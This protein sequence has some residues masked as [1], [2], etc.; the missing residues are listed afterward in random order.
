M[1]I[2]VPLAILLLSYGFCVAQKTISEKDLRLVNRS[3]STSNDGTAIV[4][5]LDEREPAGMAWINGAEF[6]QGTIEVDIKGRDVLQKSF[7]GIA[8]HGVDNTNYEAVYFRPFNFHAPDATRREH[9]VQYVAEPDY[10]WQRLRTEHPGQY[11]KPVNPAP[12][13]EAWF[14][15]KIEIKENIVKVYVN[16][17]ST[18]SLTVTELVSTGG[19][20]IGYWAGSDS[21]GNWKNLTVTPLNN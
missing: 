10:D 2:Y 8:F 21:D 12:D 17:S 7:V 3:V 18:P 9:M 19:K 14:H 1:K 16:G 4:I 20:M 11:E 15:A 6:T 13:A 5:H